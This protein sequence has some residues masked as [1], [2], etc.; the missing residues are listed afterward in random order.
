MV[1]DTIEDEIRRTRQLRQSGGSTVVTIP[2]EFI[3]FTE[4]KQGDDV[5][6]VADL[7]GNELT[8]RRTEK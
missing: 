8:I 4:F 2:P 7:N 6:L 5:D 3:E 1:H